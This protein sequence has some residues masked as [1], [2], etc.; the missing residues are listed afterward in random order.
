MVNYNMDDT[1]KEI[2]YNMSE[3]YIKWG[4]IGQMNQTHVSNV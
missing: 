3:E 1:E 4:N 2:I